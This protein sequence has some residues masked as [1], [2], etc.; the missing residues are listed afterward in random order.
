[1]ISGTGASDVQKVTFGV[2]DF[3]K[4]SVVSNRFDAILKWDNLVITGHNDNGA[5][6]QPLCEVHGA[7]RY[8]PDRCFNIIIEHFE[9]NLGLFNCSTGPV[10]FSR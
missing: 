8:V 3:L 10:K 9:G 5:K 1:M 2:I 6:L 7:D 4:V